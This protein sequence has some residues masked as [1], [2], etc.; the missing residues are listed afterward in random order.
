MSDHTDDNLNQL[1]ADYRQACPD[2]E[3]SAAFTPQ[4]WQ[5][6]EARRGFST[7][8]RRFAQVVVSASAALSL[9]MAVLLVTPVSQPNNS[10]T[11]LEILDEEQPHETLAYADVEQPD[12]AGDLQ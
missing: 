12:P 11:Y 4:L 5:K 6:I 2:F 1:F 7:R 3:G 8:L 10:T 9:A